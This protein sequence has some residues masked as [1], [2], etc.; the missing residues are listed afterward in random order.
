M[1]KMKHKELMGIIGL[2]GLLGFGSGL[3]YGD[4]MRNVGFEEGKKYI[5]DSLD[6]REKMNGFLD[7]IHIFRFEEG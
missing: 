6:N 5:I 3:L 7:D 4:G 1:V 2:I